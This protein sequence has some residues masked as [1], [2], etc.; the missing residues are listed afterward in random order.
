MSM[1]WLLFV[2]S[3]SRVDLRV[4]FAARRW[5]AAG[6]AVPCSPEVPAT[7]GGWPFIKKPADLLIDG[8]LSRE[9]VSQPTVIHM[10]VI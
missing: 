1:T 5:L 3:R 8:G 9:G 6:V 2:F 4:M 10:D 7:A